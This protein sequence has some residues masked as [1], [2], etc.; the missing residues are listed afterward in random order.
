MNLHVSHDRFLRNRTSLKISNVL[1][2]LALGSC[3]GDVLSPLGGLL[4]EH[5]LR[6]RVSAMGCLL[7]CA[8]GVH[9]QALTLQPIQRVHESSGRKLHIRGNGLV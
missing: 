8:F 9:V 3:S 5:L 2:Q 1:S 6:A 7:R 4:D